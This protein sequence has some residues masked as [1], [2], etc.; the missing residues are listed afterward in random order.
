M[1]Y[2]SDK[3]YKKCYSSKLGR[4]A[5]FVRAV[6]AFQEHNDSVVTQKGGLAQASAAAK[7]SYRQGL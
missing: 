7:V 1:M 5:E 2:L 3:N 6:E 4:N